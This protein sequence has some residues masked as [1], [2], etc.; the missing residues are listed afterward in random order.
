MEAGK[1]GWND[2][3][4][5]L[6]GLFGSEMPAAYELHEL[7]DFTATAIDEA[8]R[9]VPLP[10][11]LSEL[12]DKIDEQLG[13]HEAGRASDFEYW[14][15]VRTA[16]EEYRAATSLTFSG[17]LIL[18]DAAKLGKAN[19]LLGRM[20]RKQDKGIARALSYAPDD[21]HKVSPTYF[22]FTVKKFELVGFSSSRGLPTVRVQEFDGQVLP[23]FLEGPVR[24]MKT[25]KTA[26]IAEKRAVYRAVKNSTLR[27]TKLHMYKISESLEGQPFEVGRM[28]AFNPGWLENESIWMHMS[29]KWYLEL[30]RAGLFDEYFDE[31][32]QGVVCFMDPARFGRSPLEAASFIVS[33]AFP[34]KSLHGSGFLARLSGTTAEFLSMWNIMMMGEQP[35]VLDDDGELALALKPAIA[36]WMWTDEGTLTFRFL[37]AVDVTYVNEDKTATWGPDAAA[38]AKFELFTHADDRAPAVTVQGGVLPAP[39][40]ANVR[41][42]KYAAIKVTLLS[43]SRR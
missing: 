12:L 36:D 27:D 6:P 1:P 17:E 3:M 14:D 19:G 42:L 32:R 23:L 11:E 8:G 21:G 10:E 43:A 15:A 41:A 2:A 22:R 7:L 40:A 20:L 18:W 13:A 34:D 35:F 25:L 16:L 4:N 37:G 39:H 5:G 29:Y 30:L 24:H 33:S 31:I 26:P 28:M 38:I 9:T